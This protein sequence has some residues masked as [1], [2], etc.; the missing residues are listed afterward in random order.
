MAIHGTS[1][2]VPRLLNRPAWSETPA[3]GHAISSSYFLD[4]HTGQEVLG[5]VRTS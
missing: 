5:I 3:G 2:S 1:L 4:R